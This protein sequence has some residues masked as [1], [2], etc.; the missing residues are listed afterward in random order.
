MNF[1]GG[2]PTG[3][4]RSVL[5]SIRKRMAS[6]ISAKP[7]KAYGAWSDYAPVTRCRFIGAARSTSVGM[8]LQTPA[9]SH[10]DGSTPAP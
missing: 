8:T 5:P 9:G 7:T 2:P 4:L 10:S 1:M 3:D 6:Q